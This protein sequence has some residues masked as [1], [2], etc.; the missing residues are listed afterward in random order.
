MV[1]EKLWH[2]SSIPSQYYFIEPSQYNL[3]YALHC[4]SLC[5]FQMPDL[6]VE[7]RSGEYEAECRQQCA[8]NLPA[9][10]VFAGGPPGYRKH[11][12]H[13]ALLS[14][15]TDPSLPVR[16]TLALSFHQV[17][18]VLFFSYEFHG[19]WKYACND[20]RPANVCYDMARLSYEV[21]FVVGVTL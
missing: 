14:F 10:I 9:M 8:Y 4:P 5:H 1:I 3:K 18:C 7:V 13:E 12:L 20:R 11:Q 19:K 2:R 15:I 21:A 6:V 17:C 16:N